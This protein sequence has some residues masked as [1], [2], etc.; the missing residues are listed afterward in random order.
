M[1]KKKI[2]KSIK[3]LL[4]A[5]TLLTIIFGTAI[6]WPLPKLTPPERHH[7]TFIESINIVDV[8]SGEITYNQYILIENNIIIATDTLEYQKQ[9]SDLIIN[10]KGKYIIPGLWDMHTHSNQLSEWLH[11]PLYI[12]NGVTGLR[13]MSGQLNKK[14]SYWAG[15]KERLQWNQEVLDNI[16]VAPKYVLQSSYQMDGPFSIP[17]DYPTYFKLERSEDVDAVLEFYKNNDVD[18]IKVYQQISPS[19]Y[20]RLAIEAPKY[21]LHLAGHKPI[22]VS[23][24]E[25]INLGQRSFEHGRVFMFDA[26]PGADSLRL[27]KDWKGFYQ[28][29]KKSMIANFDIKKAT[30]LMTLMRERDAYWTPTLQTLKFEAFVNDS[31]FLQNPHLKYISWVTKN[32]WWGFDI[33]NTRKRNLSS[34]HKGLSLAF[35]EASK[36]HVGMANKIGVPIMTGTDVTDSYTFAGFS[37]HEELKELT[38]SGLSNLGALQSAT[39]IPAQFA[40][41][42]HI[43]GSIAPGKIADLLIL[44]KNPLIKITN[45]KSIHGVILNGSYYSPNVIKDLKDFTQS[46]ASSF[47][48]NVK[49]IYGLIKSPLIRLQFAD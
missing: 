37:I 31:S 1:K 20:T 33:K 30:R 17:D 49:V 11:H 2:V 21:G 26:F 42:E 19:S 5:I 10:G 47:H 29:S 34:P 8:I 36:K 14:D 48:M 45:S 40:N 24:E 38:D 16:R 25:S 7:R 35:F 13:D 46:T 15:S 39:I 44:N 27:T 9:E 32:L 18:F 12:A 23:L 28:K 3:V 41:L 6:L 4:V 43:Y 22:F